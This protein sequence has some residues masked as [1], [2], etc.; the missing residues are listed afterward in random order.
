MNEKTLLRRENAIIRGLDGLT[1]E[2]MKA[3]AV[4]H[5]Q[6]HDITDQPAT[7]ERQRRI[8]RAYTVLATIDNLPRK[9]FFG[10]S[11][12]NPTIIMKANP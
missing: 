7:T 1:I 5:E 10:I 4:L 6:G 2:D 3:A 8:K 11:I 12:D 9:H